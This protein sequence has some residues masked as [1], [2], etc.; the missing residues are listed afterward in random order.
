MSTQLKLTLV[1]SAHTVIWLFFNAIIFYSLYAVLTNRIDKLFWWC[2]AL[3][4]GEGLVLLIFR[5]QCPLTLV[6]RKYS[7]SNRDNF[8]IFL[9]NWL[10]KYNK[11]IYSIIMA[12][13]VMILLYRLLVQPR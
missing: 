1:K 13:V 8:D 11:L 12:A 4:A 9:P 3:V 5:M 2:L 7:E 10:A 6:A